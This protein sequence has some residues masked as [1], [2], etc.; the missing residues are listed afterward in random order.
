MTTLDQE[1]VA[2]ER[3]LQRQSQRAQSLLKTLQ[4]TWL[5]AATSPA[6]LL[7]AF[8]GGALLG[9]GRSTARGKGSGRSPESAAR[10]VPLQWLT[11]EASSLLNWIAVFHMLVDRWRMAPK[12]P[13]TAGDENQ[14]REKLR[15]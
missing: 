7:T 4:D 8:G 3:E 9:A 12:S 1:I 13:T 6:T 15:A 5:D 2:K 14:D 11:G 10:N